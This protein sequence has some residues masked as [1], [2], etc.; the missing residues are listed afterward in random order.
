[1]NREELQE[2]IAENI[3][4]SIQSALASRKDT[5]S[6]EDFNIVSLLEADAAADSI[7]NNEPLFNSLLNEIFLVETPGYSDSNNQPCP[8]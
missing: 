3:N 4:K 6:S 7:A 1:M 5:N 8:Q 2:R